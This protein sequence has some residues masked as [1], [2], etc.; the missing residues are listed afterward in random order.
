MFITLII[1]AWLVFGMMAAFTL[2]YTKDQNHQVLGVTLSDAHVQAP[3]VQ[4]MLSRYKQVC[5]F[6]FL[7]SGG[8]SLLLLLPAL[9]F[10]FEFFLLM[11]VLAN[12]FFNWF[13]IHKYQQKLQALK[14]EK[15]WI[16]QQSRIITVDMNVVR[17]KGKAGVSSVWVWLFWLLS[18]LPMVYLL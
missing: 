12:L 6:I 9:G 11:L 18:F 5:I 15:G 13:V 7:L 3:E 16:Y 4:D 14:R 17:E 1:I 2:F 8:L 10:Y